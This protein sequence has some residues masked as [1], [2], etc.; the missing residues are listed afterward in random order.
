MSDYKPCSDR[1]KWPEEARA[2]ANDPKF[3]LT[4][5]AIFYHETEFPNANPFADYIELPYQKRGARTF[6]WIPLRVF[7]G[8]GKGNRVFSFAIKWPEREGVIASGGTKYHDVRLSTETDCT[9]AVA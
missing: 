9:E 5:E 8:P 3:G 1:T 6:R 4:E 2:I 7:V